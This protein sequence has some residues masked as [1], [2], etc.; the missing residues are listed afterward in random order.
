[1][2]AKSII[3]DQTT[4]LDNGIIIYRETTQ[5]YENGALLSRAYHRISLVP[6][7]SLEDVPQQVA[8]IAN[9]VWTQDVIDAYRA[10]QGNGL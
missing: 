3:G 2:L 4:V 5:V 8:D 6:G 1:M 10:S 9:V 7:Q